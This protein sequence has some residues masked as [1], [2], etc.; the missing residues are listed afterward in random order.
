MTSSKHNYSSLTQA[1]QA[2]CHCFLI[3]KLS[4]KIVFS[5]AQQLYVQLENQDQICS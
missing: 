5:Y 2:F 3:L 1:Q 4:T